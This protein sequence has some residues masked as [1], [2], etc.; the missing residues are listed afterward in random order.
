MST[1][2]KAVAHW[3][4]K[5]EEECARMKGRCRDLK[6]R[7]EEDYNNLKKGILEEKDKYTYELKEIIEN[8]TYQ[9]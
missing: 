8:L 6:N 4:K 2:R 5:S 3:Y 7:L 1:L 9:N